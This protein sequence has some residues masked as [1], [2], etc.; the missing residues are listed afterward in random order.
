MMQLKIEKQLASL[1]DLILRGYPLEL[2]LLKEIIPILS[3]LMESTILDTLAVSLTCC[4]M[5]C[6]EDNLTNGEVSIKEDDLGDNSEEELATETHF[7]GVPSTTQVAS[8]GTTAKCSESRS[9]NKLIHYFIENFPLEKFVPLLSNI[10]AN[11]RI[12]TMA[13]FALLA[14]HSSLGDT[15]HFLKRANPLPFIKEILSEKSNKSD[16]QEIRALAMDCVG[17]I[18]CG[19]HQDLQLVIDEKIFPLIF[20]ILS[21]ELSKAL[22]RPGDLS[23]ALLSGN[24]NTNSSLQ[25]TPS[26]KRKKNKRKG[27]PRKDQQQLTQSNNSSSFETPNEAIGSSALNCICNSLYATTSEQEIYLLS[28]GLL[29]IFHKALQL[30]EKDEE[31]MIELILGISRLIQNIED[32][33][34]SGF[35][36]LKLLLKNNHLNTFKHYLQ[37]F[38]NKSNKKKVHSEIKKILSF[39]RDD[40]S[41]EK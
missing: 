15:G 40:K 17:F 22:R 29:D 7:T 11:I 16:M 19:S 37:V 41:S 23:I 27:S 35:Q 21:R 13:V 33:S 39:L 1:I 38:Q 6:Q 9:N 5:I 25:M 8:I 2:N 20:I 36:A 30:Y 3:L 34:E 12:E 31:V 32:S 18:C 10:D 24:E 4:I 28:L 26:K 14:E